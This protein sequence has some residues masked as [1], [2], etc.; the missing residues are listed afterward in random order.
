[1]QLYIHTQRNTAKSIAL[2][3]LYIAYKAH[4]LILRTKH[5]NLFLNY[6]DATAIHVITVM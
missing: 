2:L 6:R 4:I 1:M 5:R 3:K